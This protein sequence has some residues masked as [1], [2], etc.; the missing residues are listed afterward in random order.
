MPGLELRHEADRRRA[1]PS[2]VAAILRRPPGPAGHSHSSTQSGHHAS[3]TANERDP[4]VTMAVRTKHSRASGNRLVMLTRLS[5]LELAL[6][7]V[8]IIFGATGSGI[9][10]GRALSAKERVEGTARGHAGGARRSRCVAA[11]LRSDDGR[12]AIRG[13]ARR[14]RAGSERDRHHLSPRPDARR[15]DANPVARVAEAIRRRSHRVV[16]VGSRLGKV[17][18]R[19]EQVGRH[20]EQAVGPRR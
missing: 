1:S 4:S 5:S 9:W 10:I 11:R 12:R 6:V 18:G 8:A 20:P 14:G 17:P 3:P 7:V 19:V 15:T 16:G 13:A 2:A